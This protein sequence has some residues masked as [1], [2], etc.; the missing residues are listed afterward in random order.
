MSGELKYF[1][2]ETITNLMCIFT[3]LAE[4][5]KDSGQ[6]KVIARIIKCHIALN[7]NLQRNAL[8]KEKRCQVGGTTLR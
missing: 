3:E 4:G 8:V 1:L 2:L 7:Y 5:C 6:W